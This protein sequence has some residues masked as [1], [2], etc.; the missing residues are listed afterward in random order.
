MLL[1]T[2]RNTDDMLMVR[3]GKLSAIDVMIQ[4]TKGS[5][6]RQQDWLAQLRGEAAELE[7]AGEPLPD[8]LR[9][10]IAATEHALNQTMAKIL[11]RLYPRKLAHFS[12]LGRVV[13]DFFSNKFFQNVAT[14]LKY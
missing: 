11:D 9:G 3:D 5:L 4:V 8:Q 10:R 14:H 6:R 1:R 12:P 7:R 13:A 2:F